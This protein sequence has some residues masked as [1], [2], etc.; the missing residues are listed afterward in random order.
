MTA[1][2]L[3]ASSDIAA[4]K[5]PNQMEPTSYPQLCK[6]TI[7]VMDDDAMMQKLFSIMLESLGYA[8]VCTSEGAETLRL[9]KRAR[10]DGRPFAGVILD[11]HN[12][13]G[14]DGIETLVDL[15]ELDMEVKAAICTADA[16]APVMDQFLSYGFR[17]VLA[18]PFGLD[19]LGNLLK[20]IL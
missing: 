7:L 9:Y 17:G 12:R 5:E 1:T 2:V 6:G 13:L 3:Y 8:S 18:K 10:D 19:D 14:K 4:N 15:R 20:H 11:L 16:D